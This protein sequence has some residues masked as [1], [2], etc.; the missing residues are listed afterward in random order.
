M[1]SNWIAQHVGCIRVFRFEVLPGQELAYQ[2]YLREVVEPIDEV[3]FAEGAF[4]EVLILTQANASAKTVTQCRVFTFRDVAQREAFP[5]LIAKA[6]ARFDKTEEARD[7]RKAYADTL[8]AVA[9][10][11]DYE[12]SA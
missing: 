10:I 1:I 7:L 9:G 5:G 11:E 2:D 6:A 8:R 12:L 3:A 4:L